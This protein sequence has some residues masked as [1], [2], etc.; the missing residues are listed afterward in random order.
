MKNYSV[1]EA[2][3]QAERFFP[4]RHKELIGS[5]A[6]LGSGK[7]IDI[8]VL[9]DELCDAR[10]T[11]RD[12]A[13]DIPDASGNEDGWTSAKLCNLN[14]I[15]TDSAFFYQAQVQSCRTLQY[16]HAVLPAEIDLTEDRAFRVAVHRIGDKL[17]YDLE[18]M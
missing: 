16:L 14:F 15:I 9:V 1:L 2:M 17:C 5:T 3:G 10:D 12:Y 6:I 8:L 13:F 4:T 7:D 11:L 18:T